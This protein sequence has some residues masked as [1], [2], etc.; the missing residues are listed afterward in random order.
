MFTSSETLSYYTKT[1]ILIWMLMAFQAGTINV[2]GL[3]I[4]HRFVSHTTGFATFFG[5]EAASGNYIEALGMLVV[6]IFFLVGVMLSAYLIDRRIQHNHRPYYPIA[7]GLVFVLI[8]INC[9]MGIKGYYGEF[10][11][12]PDIANHWFLLI[13]LCMSCGLQNATVTSVYGANVRTTHLTGLT[14]DLGIG[15]IR[16]LTHSH[17]LQTRGH[18]LIANFMR[19]GLIVSFISGSL[20]GAGLYLRFSYWGLVLPSI[21]SCGIFIWSIWRFYQHRNPGHKH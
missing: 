16:I 6:P 15:I 14:T 9:V 8:S 2:A 7:M 1:N 5:V 11:R 19:V 12:S 10:G 20:V 13:C 4:A 17:K 3:M 18:E 21:I